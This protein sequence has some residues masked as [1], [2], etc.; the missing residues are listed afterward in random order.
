MMYITNFTP[1]SFNPGLVIL[2]F[3]ENR[4]FDL[5]MPAVGSQP[6]KCQIDKSLVASELEPMISLGTTSV[7]PSHS[8]FVCFV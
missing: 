8:F 5:R 4:L 7:L 1:E 6:M 3:M 2:G